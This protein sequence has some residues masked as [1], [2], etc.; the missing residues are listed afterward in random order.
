MTVAN[1][2]LMGFGIIIIMVWMGRE[3]AFLFPGSLIAF[4][5]VLLNIPIHSI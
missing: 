2:R 3:I 4:S 1:N 5:K